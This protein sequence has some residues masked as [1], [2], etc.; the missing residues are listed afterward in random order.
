MLTVTNPDGSTEE[1]AGDLQVVYSGTPTLTWPSRME[2]HY[3]CVYLNGAMVKIGFHIC[4]FT[5]EDL[6][7]GRFGIVCLDHTNDS[8]L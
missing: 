5:V 8:H 2:A 1:V 6:P 3:D 7:G 4:N